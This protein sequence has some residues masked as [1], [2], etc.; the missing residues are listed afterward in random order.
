MTASSARLRDAHDDAD[1]AE[2]LL[3][4]RQVGLARRAAPGLIAAAPAPISAGV[5]GIARTT[6]TGLPSAAS[7]APVVMPAATDSTRSQ[8]ASRDGARGLGDV[9]RLDREQ[10]ALRRDRRLDDGHARV[11]R[12]AARSPARPTTS[13]TPSVRVAPGGDQPAEQ[14]LAHPPA[15]HDQQLHR[16]AKPIAARAL[17]GTAARRPPPGHP[18]RC[19]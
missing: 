18:G 3:R 8:P 4:P 19:R 6:G 2:D 11:L 12:R 13:T 7:I 10:R 16:R 15:T 9:A 1:R 17:R 14:G 5:F